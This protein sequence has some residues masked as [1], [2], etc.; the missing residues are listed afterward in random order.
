MGLVGSIVKKGFLG[1]AAVAAINS[2]YI[3]DQNEQ[4]VVRQ[5]GGKPVKVI[6]NP[7]DGADS[8]LVERLTEKYASEGVS[9]SKGAGLRF[10]VPFIQ[11][12]I[13]YDRRLLRWNGFPE[14]VP[15]KDK[16]YIWVDAT[17]R[18]Y[19]EDP[20]LFLRTTATEEQA[21]ARLDDN[22]D[23]MVRTEITRR[24]LI[25]V[26]RTD[27]RTMQVAEEELRETTN[28]GIVNEGRQKI[29]KDIT[30]KAIDVCR[31]YGIGIHREGV[32]LKGLTYVPEVKTA[33]EQRMISERLRIAKKYISEG[34]GAYASITGDKNRIV[35]SINSAAYRT[36]QEI[37]GTAD[38]RVTRIKSVFDRDPDFY[39]FTRRLELY[40]NSVNA[41]TKMIIGTDN[42]LFGQL[43]GRNPSP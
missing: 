40:R 39:G 1:L 13:N 31:Q 15:T 21:H 22:L 9:I 19:I 25:E 33:V 43:K 27:N 7:P 18:W 16:R 37:K 17:A 4:A 20:L 6:V 2:A 23:N 29:V 41:D 28:M 42:P 35:D 11:G 26:V 24:D 12:V 8:G 3:V 5:F 30:D 14:Q 36:A 38:G 10:K 34:E 32:L